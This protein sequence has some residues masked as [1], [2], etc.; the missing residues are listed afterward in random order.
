[1]NYIQIST[2][3]AKSAIFSINLDTPASIESMSI[4]RHAG[5]FKDGNDDSYAISAIVRVYPDD[6]SEQGTIHVSLKQF[7]QHGMPLEVVESLLLNVM[8]KGKINLRLW[9]V[10]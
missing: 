9:N 1:M 2:Q 10:V 3:S 6:H 5:D 8:R 7:N 4:H